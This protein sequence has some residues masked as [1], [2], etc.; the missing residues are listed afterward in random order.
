MPIAWCEKLHIFLYGSD[1][2]H[3]TDHKPLEVIY[4]PK[5][6][7]SA[8]IERWALRLQPYRFKI[9]YTPGT[10][11]RADFLSRLPL[12]NQP[13]IERSLAEE[14]LSYVVANA[15]PNALTLYQLQE[16]SLAD[17]TLKQVHA[18]LGSGE[19]PK[20][21]DL[22]PYFQVRTEL[23]VQN[24]LILRG[25]R[26]VVPDELRRPTLKL[27]NRENETTSSKGLVAW[28]G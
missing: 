22:R 1:F 19:W 16:A 13:H 27:A 17:S 21:Q 9:Q 2:T 20:I 24:G 6:K 3:Y 8:R 25:T 15:V 26:I 4:N 23:S 14:Y 18:C 7:P 10:E 11:N 12:R 5:R 28:D